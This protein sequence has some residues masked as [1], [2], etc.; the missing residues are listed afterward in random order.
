[1]TSPRPDP[2]LPGSR[3]S[4]FASAQQPMRVASPCWLSDGATIADPFHPTIE[5]IA[6]LKAPARQLRGDSAIRRARWA[7]RIR[8][9]TQGY[10]A[11]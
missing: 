10:R 4:P 11:G 2:P 8:P 7:V 1:M 3:S 5:L 9:R 6:L